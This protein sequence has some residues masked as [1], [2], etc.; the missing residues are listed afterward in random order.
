MQVRLNISDS[1]SEDATPDDEV[2]VVRDVYAEG[3][4]SLM[5]SYQLAIAGL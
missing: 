2:E 4:F 3:A 1:S 5:A